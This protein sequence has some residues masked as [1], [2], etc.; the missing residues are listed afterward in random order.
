MVFMIRPCHCVFLAKDMS[1]PLMPPMP[2]I[3]SIPWNGLSLS[4]WDS[5]YANQITASLIPKLRLETVRQSLAV[6]GRASGCN[7]NVTTKVGVGGGDE[8]EVNEVESQRE[9]S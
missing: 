6:T 9:Y 1:M 5:S 3:P 7:N 8:V 4:Q 2:S